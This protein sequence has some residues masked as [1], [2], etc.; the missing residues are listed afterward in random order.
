[1]GSAYTDNVIDIYLIKTYE[2]GQEDWSKKIDWDGYKEHGYFVQQTSDGGYIV[3]AK[4]T[5]TPSGFYDIW[6]IKTDSN[7]NEE[8]NQTYGGDFQEAGFV[9]REIDDGYII[10]ASTSSFGSGSRDAWLIKTDE[11]GEMIWN[12]TYGEQIMNVAEMYIRLLMVA[13]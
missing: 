9:V 2:N 3:C 6:L 13:T 10:I 4:T 5:N 1:V 8:W 12:Q 11:N 7:G